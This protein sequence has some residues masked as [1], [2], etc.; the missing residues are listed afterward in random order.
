MF[1]RSERHRKRPL[2]PVLRPV[3]P[4]LP[5][6]AALGLLAGLLE[7]AGVSLFI[8][9]LA[10]LLSDSLSHGRPGPIHELAGLFNR[11]D[12]DTGVPLG[13]GDPRNDLGQEWRPSSQTKPGRTHPRSRWP[14]NPDQPLGAVTCPGY[15]FFLKHEPGRLS[16]FFPSIAGW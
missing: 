12:L 8:P 5:L 6:V 15:T 1:W 9:L 13:R 3:L 2:A 4:F 7:G 11:V 10:F 14:R 16:R